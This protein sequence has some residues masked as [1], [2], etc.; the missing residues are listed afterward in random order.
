MSRNITSNNLLWFETK[1]TYENCEKEVKELI[2]NAHKTLSN[3]SSKSFNYRLSYQPRKYDQTS[4]DVYLWFY[5][6]CKEIVDVL[7]NARPATVRHDEIDDIPE[8]KIVYSTESIDEIKERLERLNT[9]YWETHY[10]DWAEIADR[11][12]EMTELNDKLVSM[13]YGSILDEQYY[14]V[15]VFTPIKSSTKDVKPTKRF[16][17]HIKFVKGWAHRAES[18]YVANQLK[19]LKVSPPLLD[20]FKHPNTKYYK[21]L[22]EIMKPFSTDGKADIKVCG[23]E[24]IITFKYADSASFALLMNRKGITFGSQKVILW[25]NNVQSHKTNGAQNRR[26]NTKYSRK[27]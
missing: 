23:G 19:L 10:E 24:V 7:I 9:S 18:K 1:D 4:A 6:D 14:I 12:L 5:G 3:S 8:E 20:H 11:E 16:T 26:H 27:H 13:D 2:N 22:A 17:S 15:P 25:Y 21:Q